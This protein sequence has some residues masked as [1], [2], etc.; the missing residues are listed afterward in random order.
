MIR[1]D[2][3]VQS[4]RGAGFETFSGV[5]CSFLKPL[6]NKIV[7]SPEVE[8]IPA[9]NEGDAVAI[10]C[11]FELGGR[12]SVVMCQNSGLG[13]A[14]NPLTSLT[15]ALR[16]P[17]L[18]IVTWRGQPAEPQDEPQHEMMGRITPRLLE[19]MGIPWEVFPDNEEGLAPMLGRAAAHMKSTRTP[20]GIIMKKGALGPYEPQTRADFRGE[21]RFNP[22][23]AAAP[24]TEGH[25]Q[26]DVLRIIQSSVR[27]TDVVLATTGY[28][29]RALYALGDRPNQLYSVGAMGCVSSLGLG[30]A[31]AQPWRRVVVLDGDGAVLMRMGSLATIGYQR[32]S[33]LIHILLDNGVHDSTGGQATV[34][35]TIDLSAVA[36]AC[37]YPRVVRASKLSDVQ[38][39]LQADGDAALTFVHVKTKPRRDRKL[40]RPSVRPDEVAERLRGWL[41]NRT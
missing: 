1:A 8:Y 7:D 34:S 6:I 11:G 23:P 41:K 29:G 12:P 15:A 24:A 16:I 32:P 18:V 13:N 25:E 37:Y 10:A 28:T 39:V 9:A 40:P 33:N 26:D 20:F 38:S 31:K 3:F 30:L 14:V 35:T 22:P 36:S 2:A 4:L 19:L 27:E 17:V 21:R 5:P